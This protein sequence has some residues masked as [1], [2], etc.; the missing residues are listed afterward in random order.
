MRRR[1]IGPGLMTLALTLAC[2]REPEAQNTGTCASFC[3]RT[4]AAG[5]PNDTTEACLATCE[6]A[7]AVARAECPATLGRYLGCQQ[8]LTIQCGPSGKGHVVVWEPLEL[9]R[10]ETQAYAACIFCLPDAND[11]ACKACE[12]VECCAEGKALMGD[13]GLFA[14]RDCQLECDLFDQSCHDACDAKYAS[15]LARSDALYACR[16][17]RCGC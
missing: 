15:V 7:H 9:C 5:C 3:E 17:A 10:A 14:I 2:A 11:D 13:P 16:E 8:E 12:R 4:L 6:E 1:A